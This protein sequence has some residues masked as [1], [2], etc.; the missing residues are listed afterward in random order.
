MDQR[1]K[2]A[3][4][5]FSRRQTGYVDIPTHGRNSSAEV[6]FPFL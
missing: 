1:N 2:R 5:T 6:D 4:V 3:E